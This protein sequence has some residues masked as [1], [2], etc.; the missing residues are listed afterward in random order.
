MPTLPLIDALARCFSAGHPSVDE[1]VE[2]SGLM[3]GRS[4]SWL[5]PLAQRYAAAFGDGVPPRR[6]DVVRFL[7]ADKPL[8]RVRRKHGG[9][10]RVRHWLSSP[11][12]MRPSEAASGWNIPAIVSVGEVAGW[13]RLDLPDLEWLADLRGLNGK[14]STRLDHYHR[15]ATIKRSGA[16][17]LIEAPKPRLK[18]IQRRILTE[19]LDRIPL[20][21]S[22]HGFARSRSIQTFAA[23]HVGK[24]VV[25]R[26]DVKDFFPSFSAARIE[27]F[28]RTA[29]YPES[30]AEIL[31]A[32]STT[33]APRQEWGRFSL[34]IGRDQLREAMWLYERRHLPQGAPSSPALANLCAWR[35][36]SRLSGLAAA[37]GAT[38]T[39]YADDLAFSGDEPFESRVELFSLHV[40]A[41]LLEEGFHANHRKTRIMRS[42][43]RQYLA[44]LVANRRVNVVRADFDRLRAILHNSVHRGPESQ[45]R[46]AHADWRSHLAGRVAFVEATNAEKGARLR[47][48]FEQ[49]HW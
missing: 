15:T 28:F 6:R 22:V 16:I 30:V 17:R 9:E 32:L 24:R 31:A 21:P 45:N 42:G 14:G 19:I 43:V 44:G 23:P 34:D 20:H 39:R 40:A 36:D 5:R 48:L 27:S 26:M 8:S 11:E 41:I 25:L 38:Y 46:N 18:E 2:R 10:L 13:L 33:A 3:L 12:M 1:I 7:L 35:I 29:G 47:R 49:I 37:A 4:G